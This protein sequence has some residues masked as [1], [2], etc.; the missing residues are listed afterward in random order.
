MGASTSDDKQGD[1]SPAFYKAYS[2][3]YAEV[4]H[5]FL[6]SVYV[7]S[8]HPAL[9][10]DV[11]LLARLKELTPGRRGLDAGCGAG[12]R[13]VYQFW[14][15]GYDVDG[16]DA[17]E[18]N[19]QQARALHP[20]IAAR[21][22]VADLSLSLHYP[23]AS[24]DFLMCNAVIQHIAPEHV[25]DVTLGELARILKPQGVLQLMFKIGRGVNTVYDR[26][27]GAERSFLLYDEHEV[28][29]ALRSYKMEL[30]DA[31]TPE[32]LGGVMYFTDPKPM[33]HCVFYVRKAG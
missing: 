27:Y 1:F 23:D 3:R 15:D 31:E 20:D 4:A 22:S 6:Q 17:I 21:V 25:F 9:T 18:E 5:Q 26:D 24:F 12:A 28:L 33:D 14:R 29:G 10:G 2:Q 7:K 16:I 11:D 19:I 30:V 32:L 13:D 8:S